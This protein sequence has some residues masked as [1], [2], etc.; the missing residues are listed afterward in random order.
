MKHVYKLTEESLPEPET[1]RQ[2]DLRHAIER[3]ALLSGCGQDGRIVEVLHGEDLVALHGLSG[4]DATP[5]EPARRVLV[6][7]GAGYLGSMLTQKLLRRGF[8]VRILDSFIYGRRSLESFA[9]DENLEVIEGI[10][11]TFIPA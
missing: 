2:H 10:C 9:G 8:R 1:G 6:V 5:T 3:R 7:G 11:A 4:M